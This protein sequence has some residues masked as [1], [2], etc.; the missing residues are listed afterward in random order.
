MVHS[1]RRHGLYTKELRPVHEAIRLRL[2]Q[3]VE[4]RISLSEAEILFRVLYRFDHHYG[5]THMGRCKY[6]P[7]IDWKLIEEYLN[8]PFKTIADIA[9]IVTKEST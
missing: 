9:E 7:E 3:L 5:E 2:L 4:E 6:P 1:R 8:G